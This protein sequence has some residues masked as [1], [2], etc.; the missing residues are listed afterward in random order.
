ML[1]PDR[2]NAIDVPHPVAFEA[3]KDGLTQ[4]PLRAA[5]LL[6]IERDIAQAKREEASPEVKETIKAFFDAIESECDIEI[7]GEPE[8]A[9]KGK[10]KWQRQGQG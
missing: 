2:C 8:T 4:L 5:F 9:P 10:G 1:V 3:P 7:V 6:R